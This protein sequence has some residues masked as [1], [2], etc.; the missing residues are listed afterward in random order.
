[1]MKQFMMTALAVVVAPMLLHAAGQTKVDIC[2][3]DDT[4]TYHLITIADPA[5]DAHIAHGDIDVITFYEDNDGDGFGTTASTVEDCEQPEGYAAVAGDCDDTN[6][7]VNPGATEIPGNGIDDDCNPS[8]PDEVT[9][10][11]DFEPDTLPSGSYSLTC[12]FCNVA[13]LILN[14]SCADQFTPGSV[15]QADPNAFGCVATQLDLAEC[16]SEGDIAN[17]NGSLA[18]TPCE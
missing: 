9:S 14:C 8:T 16:D 4:G 3:V 5:Y 15:C 17:F 10:C 6:A 13:G 7:A 1:M 18:C 12:G 11:G 2:H